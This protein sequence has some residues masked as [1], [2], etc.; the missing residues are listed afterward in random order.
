MR[1]AWLAIVAACGGGAALDA[2]APMA[3]AAAYTVI[4][5]SESAF[6]SLVRPSSDGA[7]LLVLTRAYSPAL[8]QLDLGN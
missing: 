1:A 3:D 2:D 8:W 6:L 5:T 7:T 4:T